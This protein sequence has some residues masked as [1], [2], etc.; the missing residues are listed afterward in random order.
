MGTFPRELGV[1][2]W[3]INSSTINLVVLECAFRAV[4]GNASCAKEGLPAVFVLVEA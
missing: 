4:G 3:G 1:S 2:G